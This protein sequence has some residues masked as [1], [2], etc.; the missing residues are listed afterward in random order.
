[1]TRF[2]DKGITFLDVDP[3]EIEKQDLIILVYESDNKTEFEKMKILSNSIESG[4]IMTMDINMTMSIS[5]GQMIRYVKTLLVNRDFY[6]DEPILILYEIRKIFKQI[7][8]K[9]K[10]KIFK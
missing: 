3:S 5:K 10:D 2:E 6:K 8:R 4:R 9:T 1:M 7:L